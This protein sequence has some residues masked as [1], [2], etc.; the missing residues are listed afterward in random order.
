M[1]QRVH[2]VSIAFSSEVDTGSRQEKRVKQKAGARFWFYQN[3]NGSRCHAVLNEASTGRTALANPNAIAQPTREATCVLVFFCDCGP[4]A[5]K[6]E[7]RGFCSKNG[8]HHDV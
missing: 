6:R 2:E 1:I 5:N 8:P 7:E 3:R 4:V